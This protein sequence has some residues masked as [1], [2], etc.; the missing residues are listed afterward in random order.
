MYADDL[1]KR[2][3][4]T[5]GVLAPGEPL[6]PQDSV[7]GFEALNDL[8]DGWAAQRLTIFQTLRNL[9]PL[10]A[11]QGSP[12]T[13]IT[14]GPGGTL[15]QVRPLWIPNATIQVATTTPPFEY[16]LNILTDESYARTAIKALTAA[17]C[18]D[19]YYDG[20]FQTSGAPQGLGELFLYP[21]PDGSLPLSLV[22]YTPTP[23]TAF[24][25]ASHTAYTFPPGYAEA[26]RY[27][28]AK[29]LASDYGQSL[30]PEAAELAVT[31]F[32]VIQ[33]PNGRIPTLRNDVR[34]GGGGVYN[35]R[36]GSMERRG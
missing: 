7:A 11:G 9:Y 29:R 17:L 5:L 35:W 18:Y 21:V 2:A 30:T 27:Q 32:G 28:L 14:I 24:A 13:P 1:T 8:L 22:L 4:R 15:N 31:S 3:L 6:P 19:L 23:L 16:P 33:R 10:T 36:T 25:D 12:T 26:L 20:K 34:R